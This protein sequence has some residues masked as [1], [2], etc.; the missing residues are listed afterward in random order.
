MVRDMEL[1]DFGHL[2]LFS[3]FKGHVLVFVWQKRTGTKDEAGSGR[4]DSVE[5]RI[6]LSDRDGD[7]VLE[8]LDDLDESRSCSARRNKNDTGEERAIGFLAWKLG[9]RRE[10]GERPARKERTS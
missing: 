8:P 3:S 5:A 9:G 2:Q 7:F 6:S 4:G 10:E 1:C